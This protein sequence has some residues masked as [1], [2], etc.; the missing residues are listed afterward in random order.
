MLSAATVSGARNTST[1]IPKFDGFQMC[2]PFTRS[3]YFDMI[4]TTAHTRYG[5]TAGDRTRMPTL[6]PLMY[7]LARFGNFPV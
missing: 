3:T 5:H 2:R 1:E 4:E 6:M 7:A